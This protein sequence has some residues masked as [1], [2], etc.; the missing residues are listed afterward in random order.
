M[1]RSTRSTGRGA[2]RR[3]RAVDAD[4]QPPRTLNELMTEALVMEIEAAQRYLEFAGLMEARAN[5]PV[6]VLFRKMAA[7]EGRHAEQIMHE[8]G[9]A[10]APAAP[11]KRI[12]E[13][14]EAPESIPR[15]DLTV[16]A[17]PWHALAMALAAE[18]RAEQFFA[19]LAR[20]A[21]VDAVRNAAR[22]LQREEEDHVEL[23]REWMTRVAPPL[24]DAGPATPSRLLD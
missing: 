20:E 14:F 13:G 16:Y 21:T 10:T 7:T 19:R 11:G 12:W 8:M 18:Q 6:A 1:S 24:A 5:I 9:W 23:I 4:A 15:P 2:Y 3:S 17:Q 22:E